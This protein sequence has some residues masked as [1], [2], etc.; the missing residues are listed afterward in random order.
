MF[1]MM[2]IYNVAVFLDTINAINVRLCMIVF[3]G[4]Y[5]FVPLPLTLTN[6][7]VTAASDSLLPIFKVQILYSSL[8]TFTVS[9]IL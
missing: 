2:R 1:S 9:C 4:L 7:K 6:I 3:I 8:N 5:Q